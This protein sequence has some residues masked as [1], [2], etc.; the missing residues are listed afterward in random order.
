MAC[1]RRRRGKWVADYRDGA[2][3]RRWVTCETRKQAEDVLTEGVREARQPTRPVVDSNITLSAYA[4]R[5]LD[6][7][8]PTIK[9]RTHNGYAQTLRLHLLPILGTTKVRLLQKGRIKSFLAEKLREGKV[10]KIFAG[11]ISTEV[12]GPL[13][14][15]SVRIIHA[16][17]RAMLNAAVD[18]G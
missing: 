5:W 13:A 8:A 2:G 16:T 1:I 9:P 17:L 3:I 15:H 4:E 6:L 11:T 12:R 10:K 7:I 18:D 14:R